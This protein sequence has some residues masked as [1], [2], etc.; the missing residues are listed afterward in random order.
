MSCRFVSDKRASEQTWRLGALAMWRRRQ[1]LVRRRVLCTCGVASV[2]VRLLLRSKTIRRGRQ[3]RASSPVGT[4]TQYV[5]LATGTRLFMTP[6]TCWDRRHAPAARWRAL[7]GEVHQQLAAAR[8]CTRLPDSP[9]SH[10]PDTVPAAIPR[11]WLMRVP[12][13]ACP[14]VT[15]A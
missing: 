14:R 7:H 3:P 11:A 8:P 5:L 2:S 12:A 10:P 13:V 4:T 6:H 1:L 15:A 9:T